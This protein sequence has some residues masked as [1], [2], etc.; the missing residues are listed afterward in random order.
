LSSPGTLIHSPCYKEPHPPFEGREEFVVIGGFMGGIETIEDLALRIS[1][2]PSNE[3][4]KAT[5]LIHP[6]LLHPAR[7][8]EVE[9]TL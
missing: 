2:L 3:L 9:R 1:L 6:N 4:Y 5:E 8:I 7:K